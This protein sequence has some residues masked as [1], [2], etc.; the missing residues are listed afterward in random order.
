MGECKSLENTSQNSGW[1]NW[2]QKEN[3]G[4]VE[5]RLNQENKSI[6][7]GFLKRTLILGKV[8]V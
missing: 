1:E 2:M 8:G 7:N 5:E 4:H 3:Y 6:Q